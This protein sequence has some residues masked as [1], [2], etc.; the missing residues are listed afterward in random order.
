MPYGI[1]IGKERQEVVLAICHSDMFR[2]QV[3][4]A[5][6]IPFRP[7]EELFLEF[8]LFHQRMLV[9]LPAGQF[10]YS[11]ITV[12]TIIP[13]RNIKISLLALFFCICCRGCSLIC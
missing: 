13:E 2:R 5:I 12:V 6:L 1:F 11:A 9:R 8:F 4:A 3:I 10:N 7:N